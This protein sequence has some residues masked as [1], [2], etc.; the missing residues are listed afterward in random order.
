MTSGRAEEAV[1]LLHDDL[2]VDMSAANESGHTALHIAAMEGYEEVI[3]ALLFNGASPDPLDVAGVTPLSLAVTLNLPGCVKRL[4][5]GKASPMARDGGGISPLLLAIGDAGVTEA[6]DAVLASVD[7]H[8]LLTVDADHLLYVNAED[9]LSQQ[10]PPSTVL[11]HAALVGDNNAA[12]FLCDNG[13]DIEEKN[14]DGQTALHLSTL[15][16][17][18]HKRLGCTLTL[19]EAGASMLA[20]DHYGESPLTIACK[21]NDRFLVS[22]DSH[23]NAQPCV[24]QYRPCVPNF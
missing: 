17:A 6:A 15:W 14:H 19:V 20:C 8:V 12:N 7:Y 11:H 18:Q 21:L 9:L 22:I 23:L 3:D 4:L 1:A 13:A 24:P 10:W 5:V 2:L 16:S